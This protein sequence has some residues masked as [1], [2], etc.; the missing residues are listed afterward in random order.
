MS[1]PGSRCCFIKDTCRGRPGCRPTDADSASENLASPIYRG[2]GPV[3]S[4]KA[5]SR[6]VGGV[7]PLFTEK[8][9]CSPRPSATPL[10]NEGG[11]IVGFRDKNTALS[12]GVFRIT[13]QIPYF[14]PRWPR[15]PRRR[16]CGSRPFPGRGHPGWWSRRGSRRRPSFCRGGRRTAASAP[17]C[18]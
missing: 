12:G 9:E 13:W 2:G 6:R 15:W 3:D 11:K 7:F 18:R 16:R 17:R 8:R 14:S 10:I 5:R 4:G 1:S